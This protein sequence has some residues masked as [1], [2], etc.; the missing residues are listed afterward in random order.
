[1]TAHW[2]RVLLGRLDAVAVIYRLAA[3]VADAGDC[4]PRFGWYRSIPLDA[5]LA[6]D[7]GRTLGVI[8]Q[9]AAADRTGF[10]DRIGRL[11]DPDLSRARALLALTLSLN[12]FLGQTARRARASRGW[13]DAYLCPHRLLRQRQVVLCLQV[14]PE[15][16]IHTEPVTKPES[17]VT[18]HS[19]LAGQDLADAVAWHVNVPGEARRRH[20]SLLQLLFQN[21]PRVYG[22]F[23]HGRQL[24]P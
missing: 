10:S 23:Q 9:G 11:L 20:A 18:R 3:T 24:P 16:G 6:L 1:M 22:S 14:Q 4:F 21:F 13:Q 5:A 2:Q 19:T 12:L 8:R 7:G 17:A 15:L